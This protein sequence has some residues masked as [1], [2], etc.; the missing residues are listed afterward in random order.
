MLAKQSPH[1]SPNFRGSIMTRFPAGRR[2]ACVCDE[3]GYEC[4]SSEQVFHRQQTHSN[5]SHQVHEHPL[6]TTIS[7]V[8][9]L[10]SISLCQKNNM[11]KSTARA[12]LKDASHQPIS[13]VTAP[14]HRLKP[15]N[16][17]N[18]PIHSFFP[19][20]HGIHRTNPPQPKPPPK[21]LC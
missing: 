14:P 19:Q 20:P 6:Y 9:A 7:N 17:I 8:R 1:R 21:L 3:L 12:Q 18:H 11:G 13:L 15:F 4:V 10:R 5:Y 16:L 2:I